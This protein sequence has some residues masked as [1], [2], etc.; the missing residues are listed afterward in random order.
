MNDTKLEACLETQAGSHRQSAQIDKLAAAL[1]KMQ[2]AMRTAKK[3]GKNPHFGS[4]YST[5][6]EVWET[7]REPLTANGLAVVQ[8]PQ[9]TQ[10]A[11]VSLLTMLT[12]ESGQ[13]LS[14][15]IT[16]PLRPEFTKSGTELPPSPQQI[17]SC[18][19][20]A[21]RYALSAM[22]GVAS[23][24]DDDGNLASRV[25]NEPDRPEKDSKP[26]LKNEHVSAYPEENKKVEKP[27]PAPPAKPTPEPK[28]PE[29]QPQTKPQPQPKPDAK[30]TPESKPAAT[31]VQDATAFHARLYDACQAAG[32]TPA[33][34]EGDLKTKGIL[35]GAMRVDN[36]GEPIVNA[37]LDGKDR[38]SGR[39]NWDIVVE[40]I[41]ANI[42]VPY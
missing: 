4:K 22:V 39:S 42:E 2:A 24:D 30:P 25:P 33:Q 14:S 23:D 9:P 41:K 29:P 35:K 40:R 31:Q 7:V 21:R 20:Y 5:L 13:Y 18:I 37:L 3:D 8:I 11:T 6:A 26:R 12:H 36:L 17:G 32:I 10:G 27:S 16:M 1:V 15:T 34:L 38:V 19:T 28:K